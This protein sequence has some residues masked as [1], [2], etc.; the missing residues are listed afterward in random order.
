MIPIKNNLWYQKILTGAN[1]TGFLAMF[2]KPVFRALFSISFH[3]SRTIPIVV[4]ACSWNQYSAS[5]LKH[6][7]RM[8]E[9]VVFYDHTH[10]Y[11]VF[12]MKTWLEI[13]CGSFTYVYPCMMNNC[14]DTSRRYLLQAWKT[15]MQPLWEPTS[16]GSPHPQTQL[17][18]GSRPTFF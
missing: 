12:F 14:I 6:L 2:H 5:D 1:I 8:R 3:P 4:F 10:T 13:N 11:Y 16:Q 18:D 7:R 15:R 17:R 9:I